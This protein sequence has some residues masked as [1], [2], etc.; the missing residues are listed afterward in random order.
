MALEIRTSLRP[1]RPG[2]TPKGDTRRFKVDIHYI[3][4]Y[5]TYKRYNQT[6]KRKSTDI[7]I[8]IY[9]IYLQNVQISYKTFK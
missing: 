3:T 1:E 9:I 7:Y 6:I 5:I 2:T 8:N 4:S